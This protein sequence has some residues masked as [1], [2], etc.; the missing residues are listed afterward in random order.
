VAARSS[1]D[2][3]PPRCLLTLV[4]DGIDYLLTSKIPALNQAA[5]R[6]GVGAEAGVEAALTAEHARASVDDAVLGDESLAGTT[7][8]RPPGEARSYW[9]RILQEKE[10]AKFYSAAMRVRRP[11]VANP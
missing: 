3:H 11:A 4:V 1:D 2:D 7:G 8:T 10:E 6:D 5:Q 9:S